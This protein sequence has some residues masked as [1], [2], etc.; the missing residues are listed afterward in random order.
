MNKNT[1]NFKHRTDRLGNTR[2]V[3]ILHDPDWKDGWPEYYAQ[4]RGGAP[5]KTM[6]GGIVR[7]IVAVGSDCD[8]DKAADIAIRDFNTRVL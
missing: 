2:I 1:E 4:I 5:V 7:P 8:P 6:N 3:E